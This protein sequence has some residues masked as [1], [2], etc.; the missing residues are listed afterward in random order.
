M[1]NGGWLF[2]LFSGARLQPGSTFLIHQL[3]R[4]IPNTI[5]ENPSV[6]FWVSELHAHVFALPLFIL[7]VSLAPRAL[8]EKSIR[9]SG[10]CGLTAACL[11]MTDS[12]LVP[13][14]ILVALDSS[15]CPAKD[16]LPYTAIGSLFMG[17]VAL[18][19]SLAFLADYHPFPMQ[20]RVLPESDTTLWQFLALFGPLFAVGGLVLWEKRS[21]PRL[22][23]TGT[24]FAISA[25]ILT[26]FCE[27]FYLQSNLPPPAERQNTVFRFHYAAWILG[28]LAI[29]AFWP[30]R[31]RSPW[32]RAGTWAL[33]GLFVFL[34]NAPGLRSIVFSAPDGFPTCESRS[35]RT[36]AA[37][38][39][40]LNGCMKTRRRIPSSR[41]VQARRIV[42]SPPSPPCREDKRC[43]EKPIK[44]TT[45]RSK[46][47]K[48]SCAITPSWAF[49]KI[50]LKRPIF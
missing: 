19:A 13:P 30:D 16:R 15:S 8:R 29:G 42:F 22:C 7:W 33:I 50:C 21:M 48:S 40:S 46:F 36:E 14:A 6:A 4:V 39:K 31:F 41:R 18:V 43:W 28:A 2:H 27:L 34:G 10:L 5:N 20:I 24:V 37:V 17:G 3:A 1:G 25:L 12:W 49:I 32:R 47:P 23:H 44:S 45:T 11:A 38:S 35:I 9:L 26:V